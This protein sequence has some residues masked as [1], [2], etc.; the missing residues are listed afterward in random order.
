VFDYEKEEVLF[1]SRSNPSLNIK[2][3][4]SSI[5]CVQATTERHTRNDPTL[6][7]GQSETTSYGALLILDDKTR[8]RLFETSGRSDL[9]D[10][11]SKMSAYDRIQVRRP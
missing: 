4:M 9:E 5:D 8:I 6:S 7:S 10:F 1:Y 3:S 11:L 2:I